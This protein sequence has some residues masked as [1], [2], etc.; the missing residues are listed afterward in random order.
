MLHTMIRNG[1]TD[2]VLSYLSSEDVLKLRNV[3][4]GQWE[5]LCNVAMA[6]SKHQR[7]SLAGYQTPR[8]LQNYATYLDT[9]IRTY[10]DLKHDP[11]R[12]QSEVNRDTRAENGFEDTRAHASSSSNGPQRSKT[13]MGRKLRSMTVEKGLLRET[14]AVQ[15]TIDTL[16]ECKVRSHIQLTSLSLL[17]N[18]TSVLL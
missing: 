13:I 7:I 5:G 2:N 10:K 17:T 9:R 12:V 18:G 4:N 3:S 6:S 14:K 8:N 16:L 15:K 1:A 11:V